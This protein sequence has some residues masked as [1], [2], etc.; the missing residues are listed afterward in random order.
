MR[1]T[2]DGVGMPTAEQ[3]RQRAVLSLGRMTQGIDVNAERRGLATQAL[4]LQRVFDDYIALRATR[5][6]L[7]IH[8]HASMR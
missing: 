4:T 8:A 7:S 5:Q 3:T 1:T 2:I 6:C